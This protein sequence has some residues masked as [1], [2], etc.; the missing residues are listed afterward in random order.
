MYCTEDGLYYVHSHAALEK[1]KMMFV[2][3][4]TLKFFKEEM[5]RF[6]RGVRALVEA[7]QV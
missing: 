6:G 5:R 2:E 4:G 3:S 1:K 7:L